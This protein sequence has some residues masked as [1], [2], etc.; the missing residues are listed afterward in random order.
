[1]LTA[2]LRSRVVALAGV[3][4][5]AAGSTLSLFSRQSLLALDATMRDARGT[6]ASVTAAAVARDLTADLQTLEGLATAPRVQ[7]PGLSSRPRRLADAIC[8]LSRDASARCAPADAAALLSD[9]ALAA[10]IH[11]SIRMR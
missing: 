10:T 11:D 7:L 5:F 6:V 4:V 1:M 8:Y 3:G 2:T 9:P